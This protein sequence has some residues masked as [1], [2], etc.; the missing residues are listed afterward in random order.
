LL[1]GAAFHKQLAI[2]AI[3]W[4]PA[5]TPAWHPGPRVPGSAVG[6]VARGAGAAQL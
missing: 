1:P 4:S 2:L 5:G 6:S 3:P